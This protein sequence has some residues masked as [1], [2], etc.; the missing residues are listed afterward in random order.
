MFLRYSTKVF[1]F[2]ALYSDASGKLSKEAFWTANFQKYGA[3]GKA[4]F[5]HNFI[6]GITKYFYGNLE[7]RNGKEKVQVK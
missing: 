1:N 6:C 2:H 5:R 3:F 7:Y 4:G